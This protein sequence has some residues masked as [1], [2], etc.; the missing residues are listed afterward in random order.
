MGDRFGL[1]WLAGTPVSWRA[2][3][4]TSRWWLQRAGGRDVGATV[5]SRVL[6]LLALHVQPPV[7]SRLRGTSRQGAGAGARVRCDRFHPPN[8]KPQL[9]EGLRIYISYTRY[10]PV[11]CDG[12]KKIV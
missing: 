9:G 1:L 10:V 5:S 6:P 8:P 7:A 11:R 3:L 4:R 2:L 12:S